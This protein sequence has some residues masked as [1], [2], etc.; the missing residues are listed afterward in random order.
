MAEEVGFSQHRRRWVRTG[1]DSAARRRPAQSRH[2][3]ASDPGC[4][5]RCRPG[6]APPA[7]ALSPPPAPPAPTTMGRPRAACS[8][9]DADP[10][11]APH[12][13]VPAPVPMPGTISYENA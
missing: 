5:P 9:A 4:A 2:C 12:G 10:G 1:A 11:R 13:A 3:A 6:R 7:P 8:A